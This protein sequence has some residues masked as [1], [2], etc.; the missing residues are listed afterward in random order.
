M[1]CGLPGGLPAGTG[2]DSPSVWGEGETEIEASVE[3]A[4]GRV[5]RVC[6]GRNENYPNWCLCVCVCVC[7]CVQV[8][9]DK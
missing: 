3:V 8:C 1:P 5:G 9:V 7:V 6:G 2:V 4:I